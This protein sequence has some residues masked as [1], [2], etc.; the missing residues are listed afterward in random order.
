MANIC[1][2]YPTQEEE[3]DDSDGCC[4]EVPDGPAYGEAADRLRE[5]FEWACSIN[6]KEGKERKVL[7][8]DGL[9]LCDSSAWDGAL[10][11]L[12]RGHMGTCWYPDSRLRPHLSRKKCP[13]DNGVKVCDL[14]EG[15][16]DDHWLIPKGMPDPPPR[17]NPIQPSPPRVERVAIP[18]ARTEADEERDRRLKQMREGILRIGPM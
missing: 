16:V 8:R 13:F 6:E 3:E 14:S 7:P 5:Q 2:G 11:R 10:C 18:P 4:Y 9:N 15:H 17:F 12:V 1:S